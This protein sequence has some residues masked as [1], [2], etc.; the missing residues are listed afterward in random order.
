MVFDETNLIIT[1]WRKNKTSGIS[2]SFQGRGTLALTLTR[3]E[4]DHG[5]GNVLACSRHACSPSKCAKKNSGAATMLLASTGKR[6][7]YGPA[8]WMYS[9]AALFNIEEG[10]VS[11]VGGGGGGDGGGGSGT[12]EEEE[13]KEEDG[14]KEPTRRVI[15]N[16]YDTS[17]ILGPIKESMISYSAL[18]RTV[19]ELSRSLIALK[20]FGNECDQRNEFTLV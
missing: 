19:T 3:K 14:G 8:G 2:S 15:L 9:R 6:L 16:F 18:L 11:G 5:I 4:I 13:E 7:E 10:S 20:Q 12:Q 17:C 1:M